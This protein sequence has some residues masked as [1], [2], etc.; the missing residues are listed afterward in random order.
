MPAND[1]PVCVKIYDLLTMQSNHCEHAMLQ[2]EYVWT[3]ALLL[4]AMLD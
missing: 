2:L 4:T 1:T 3:L